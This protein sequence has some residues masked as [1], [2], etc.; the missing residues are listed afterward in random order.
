[1]KTLKNYVSTAWSWL[2]ER[3]VLWMI[4]FMGI[5]F[6]LGLS[7]LSIQSSK[8]EKG[9]IDC[10]LSCHPEA[11][12]YIQSIQEYSCWCYQDKITLKPT[13]LHK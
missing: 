5:T 9:N 6:I 3:A 8:I 1:M 13:V 11:Y 2:Y 4:L 7:D 12:E 10:K